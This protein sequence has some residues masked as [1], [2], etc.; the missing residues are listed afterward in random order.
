MANTWQMVVRVVD[1]S[2]AITRTVTASEL[3]D[4]DVLAEAGREPIWCV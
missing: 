4:P 3:G 1:M 2:A